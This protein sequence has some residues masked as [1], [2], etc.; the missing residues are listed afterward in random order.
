MI[1]EKISKSD[2]KDCRWCSKRQIIAQD[3]GGILI[4][5]CEEI[6]CPIFKKKG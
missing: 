1:K 2:Y 3:E 4:G 6:E 5:Y